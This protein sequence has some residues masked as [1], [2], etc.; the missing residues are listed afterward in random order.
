MAQRALP[1]DPE[2]LKRAF[3]DLGLSEIRGKKHAPR[4]VRM[5]VLAG[6]PEITNDETAWCAA[7]VGAWLVEAGEE[8][9]GSLMARSYSKYGLKLDKTKKLPRGAI[10]VWPR[11]GFPGSGHVNLLLE[12]DGVYLTCIGA[13]QSNGAGGGVTISRTLKAHLVSA[14]WPPGTARVPIPR[15]KP[16]LP[17][18]PDGEDTSDD[19]SVVTTDATPSDKADDLRT[20]QEHDAETRGSWLKR[21]WRGLTG[22]F[23]GVGGVGV[24]GYLTD[25]WV[26]VAIVGALFVVAAVFIWF[27]G[28]REVRAWIRKQ[29][30]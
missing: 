23:S 17:P 18:T 24:L 16:K 29:V 21:K 6:F 7:A 2:H 26:V 4:V 30:Q 20:S 9:S 3:A 1:S 15:P 22:W 14:T 27:M 12:D 28:P 25:P 8:P 10:C 11:E 19:T 13:N 5:F